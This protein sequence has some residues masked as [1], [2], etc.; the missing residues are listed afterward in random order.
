MLLDLTLASLRA[1]KLMASLTVISVA[2]SMFVLFSV[3]HLKT[4]VKENFARSVSGVDLIVGARTSPLNLLLYSVFHIGNPSN[5]ISWQSYQAIQATEDV[6][7][8]I[9][10][11]LGDSHQ[12]YSVVGTTEAFFQHFHYADQQPLKFLKGKPFAINQEVVLGFEVAK[13]LGYGLAAPLIVAHGTGRVSFSHHSQHPF[14]VAGILAPT[15]TPVDQ[16]IYLSINAVELMHGA[17]HSTHQGESNPHML[18]TEQSN[19]IQLSAIY[20]GLASK[21]TTLQVQRQINQFQPEPLTAIMPRVAL[22]ELWRIMAV[23]ETSLSIVSSLI[24]LAAMLGMLTMLLASMHERQREIAVLRALGANAFIIVLLIESEV[25]LLTLIGCG[26]GYLSLSA[27]LYLAQDHLLQEYG[28]FI[29]PLVLDNNIAL[30]TALAIL[31]AAVLALGPA[32][33]AY[34]RS[35]NQGLI[36]S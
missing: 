26:L 14:V 6:A 23:I 33:S 21:I 16:S 10:L 29:S 32:I 36:A 34:K 17:T 12:G 24:L 8:A 11:S 30:Y 25:L 13:N 2:V 18:V 20:L 3:E 5:N 27:G 15:G 31:L 19:N 9:P 7:W 35:L 4:Q 1:R 28:L 22:G